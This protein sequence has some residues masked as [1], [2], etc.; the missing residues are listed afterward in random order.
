MFALMTVMA[1]APARPGEAGLNSNAA[2]VVPKRPTSPR[3]Y[4]HPAIHHSLLPPGGRPR[5]ASPVWVSPTRGNGE[6]VTS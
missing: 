3:R 6:P 5:D 1:A 4:S 2:K